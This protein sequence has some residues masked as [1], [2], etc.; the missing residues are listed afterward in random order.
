MKISCMKICLSLNE[1]CQLVIDKHAPGRA[2]KAN[3]STPKEGLTDANTEIL[4][5]Q[6]LPFGQNPP[7]VASITATISPPPKT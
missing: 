3:L 7:P 2:F 6:V 5:I 1:V 4:F